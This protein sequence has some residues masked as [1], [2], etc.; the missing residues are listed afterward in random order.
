MNAICYP[1][2][3]IAAM[4]SCLTSWADV[5]CA[6]ELV[7]NACGELREAEA[8]RKLYAVACTRLFGCVHEVLL[9]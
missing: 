6:P 3:V 2:T 8:E 1:H 9:R 5:T 4:D 7:P